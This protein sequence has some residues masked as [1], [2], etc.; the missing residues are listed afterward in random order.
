MELSGH[1]KGRIAE[2][3]VESIFRHAHYKVA[4][5]GRESHI[6]GLVKV[7][8]DIFVPDFLVWKLAT[9]MDQGADLR[10]FFAIEVKYRAN[11][12]WFL[13]R[14]GIEM[15]SEAKTQWPDLYFVFVTDNPDSRSSCFQAVRLHDYQPGSEPVAHN[16]HEI[17]ALGIDPSVVRKHEGVVRRLFMALAPRRPPRRAGVTHSGVRVQRLQA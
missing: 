4:R 8:A 15:C 16:L 11:L 2:A 6:E 7:G 17:R 5:V 14:Y 13:R 12:S 3:L 10:R 1:L 9:G